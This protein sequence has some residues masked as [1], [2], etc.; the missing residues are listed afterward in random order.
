[1][2]KFAGKV[3]VFPAD[4]KEYYEINEDQVWLSAR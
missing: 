1:V 3:S 2:K 4:K